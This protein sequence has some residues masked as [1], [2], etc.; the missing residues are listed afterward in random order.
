[1]LQT[2]LLLLRKSLIVIA[3]REKQTD[4]I[5]PIIDSSDNNRQIPSSYKELICDLA[6]PGQFNHIYNTTDYIK[7]HMAHA[8]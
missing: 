1:M 4:Y 7:R 6:I 3:L 2:R 8:G 5:K